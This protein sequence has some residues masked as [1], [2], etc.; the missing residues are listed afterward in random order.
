VDVAET[1]GGFRDVLRGYL[2]VAVD[3]GPLAAQAGLRPG[4]DIYGETLPNIPGGDEA[5]GRPPA[6]MGG[7]VDMF[8]Y[9]SLK[10]WAPAGRMCWWMSR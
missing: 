5:A 3:L 6:R 10:V 2:Y 7:S 4:G 8:E 1:A 9:L